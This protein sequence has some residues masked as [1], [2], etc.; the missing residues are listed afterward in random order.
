LKEIIIYHNSRCSKSRQTLELLTQK[1]YS[2]K[3]INYLDNVLSYEDIENL[4]IMLKIKPRELLRKSESEYKENNLDNSK[5]TDKEI[6]NYMVKIP[7][8]IERPIV[9][10]EDNAIIGRPPENI[11]KLL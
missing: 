8:L 1:G 7:K 4:I 6:I 10:F 11:Y 3:I 5:L 9:V 2:P